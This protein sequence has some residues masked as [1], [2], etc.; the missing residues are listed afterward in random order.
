MKRKLGEK[1]ASVGVAVELE[2]SSLARELEVLGSHPDNA[3][4]RYILIVRESLA[5]SKHE[6]SKPMKKLLNCLYMNIQAH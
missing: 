6:V 4:K 3:V 1:L 5:G 2:V